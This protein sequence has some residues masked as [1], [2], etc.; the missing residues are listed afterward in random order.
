MNHT[1]SIM[2]RGPANYD[3]GGKL[4]YPLR[5]IEGEIA[6]GLVQRLLKYGKERLV[7]AGLE[8]VNNWAVEISTMDG[9]E[10]PSYRKYSVTWKNA[11]GTEISIDGIM[12]KKGH[13][14]LDHGLNISR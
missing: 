5:E 2:K 1:I 12:T 10:I 4:Y 7:N 14:F 3:A 13:P 9:N 8:M 6:S 11:Q